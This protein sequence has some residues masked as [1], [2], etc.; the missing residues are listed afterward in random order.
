LEN[1]DAIGVGKFKITFF[2]SAPSA[3]EQYRKHIEDADQPKTLKINL[4]QKDLKNV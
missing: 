2:Q 3:E 4:E 1:G